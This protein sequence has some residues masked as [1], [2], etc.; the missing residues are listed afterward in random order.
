MTTQ[1]D[2]DYDT[3][4]HVRCVTCNKVLGNMQEPYERLIAEGYSAEAAMNRLGISRYCCRRHVLNPIIVPRG[5]NVPLDEDLLGLTQ[6]MNELQLKGG[7]ASRGVL[8]L[9]PPPNTQVA[10]QINTST[11]QA[12]QVP[13]PGT[14]APPLM[15]LPTTNIPTVGTTTNRVPAQVPTVGRG[16]T[17]QG[18]NEYFG[19]PGTIAGFRQPQ[20]A[21]LQFRAPTILPQTMGQPNA[22]RFQAQ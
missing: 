22:T 5:S 16:I 6:D 20:Q 7:G 17:T 19:T 8:I 2:L 11:L 12:K 14:G 10:T 18:A 3:Y 1:T 9:A 4:F 15:S 13:M 21:M